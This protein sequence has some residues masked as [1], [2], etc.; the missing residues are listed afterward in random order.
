MLDGFDGN[1]EPSLS[2]GYISM[3]PHVTY[4]CEVVGLF[5]DA[6][7]THGHYFIKALGTSNI[8]EVLSITKKMGG[9][10]FSSYL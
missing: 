8:F 4:V 6:F 1:A 7:E 3:S 10:I 5:G 2:M 9:H